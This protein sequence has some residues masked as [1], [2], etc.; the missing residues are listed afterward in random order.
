MKAGSRVEGQKERTRAD[1][2][3]EMVR[4]VT[5]LSTSVVPP[6]HGT[7]LQFINFVRDIHDNKLNLLQ[8]EAIVN[9]VKPSGHTQIGTNLKEKILKP[10][11]YDVIKNKK[12]LKRPILVS[13]ITDGCPSDESPGRLKKEILKCTR[14]LKENGYPPSSRQLIF[15]Q[16]RRFN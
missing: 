10:L 2:Q 7:S 9:S 3:I 15:A 13:C 1:D 6:G 16:E 14:F 5:R 8:V 11:V 12:R 4:R